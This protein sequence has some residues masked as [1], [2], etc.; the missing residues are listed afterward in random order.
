MKGALV[1][2]CVLLLGCARSTTQDQLDA[3]ADAGADVPVVGRDTGPFH[4]VFIPGQREVP[5]GGAGGFNTEFCLG[6]GCAESYQGLVDAGVAYGSCSDLIVRGTDPACYASCVPGGAFA[7]APDG[8]PAAWVL[9]DGRIQEWFC[10][11]NEP[12]CECDQICWAPNDTEAPHC[13]PLPAH[14]P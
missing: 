8:G 1:V 3:S 6:S 4:C 12:A 14:T 9:E 5:R 10:C 2:G 11:G 13:V 7:T